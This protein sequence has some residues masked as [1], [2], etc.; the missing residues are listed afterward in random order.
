PSGRAMETQTCSRLPLGRLEVASR[1]RAKKSIT[2]ASN[3]FT[4]TGPTLGSGSRRLSRPLLQTRP[5]RSPVWHLSSRDRGPLSA[6]VASPQT[7]WL[8]PSPPALPLG[9]F[10]PGERRQSPYLLPAVQEAAPFS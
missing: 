2:V 9:R 8:R 1:S 5:N 3:S 10:T 6:R 4:T 7:P